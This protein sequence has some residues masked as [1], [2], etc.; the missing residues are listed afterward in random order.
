VIQGIHPIIEKYIQLPARI[1]SLDQKQARSGIPQNESVPKKKSCPSNWH[2]F[3]QT[4]HKSHSLTLTRQISNNWF[5]R[6]ND[7][8]GLEK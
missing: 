6:I 1:S 4:T 8:S 3:S 7:R 2:M 5:P